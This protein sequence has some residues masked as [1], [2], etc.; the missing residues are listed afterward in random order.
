MS[1]RSHQIAQLPDVYLPDLT[2]PF[3]SSQMSTRC[4]PDVY[5]ILLT[6]CG[7]SDLAGDF[8]SSQMS[9]RCLPDVYQ[10]LLTRCGF[11]DLAGDLTRWL[12]DVYQIS[13]DRSATRC[14]STRSYQTC[15]IYPSVAADDYRCLPHR[16]YRV[17]DI[18]TSR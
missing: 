9:T 4:L 5:H 11:S 7:V 15:Q 16:T 2:R 8:R 12:P 13:P 17:S 10:I 18:R 14:L 1:T 3:R 6:G